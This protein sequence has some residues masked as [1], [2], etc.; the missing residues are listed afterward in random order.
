MRLNDD[1]Y[2]NE[3]S[4]RFA[5]A[6]AIYGNLFGISYDGVHSECHNCHFIVFTYS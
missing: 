4:V 5:E 2:I 1:E 6:G 3:F